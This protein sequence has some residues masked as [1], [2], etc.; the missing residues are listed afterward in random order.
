LFI[1]IFY[2]KDLFVGSQPDP[3]AMKGGILETAELEDFLMSSVIPDP[4]VNATELKQ[5]ISDELDRYFRMPSIQDSNIDVLMFWRQHEINFPLL[6]QLARDV[7]CIPA[8]SCSSERLF[9]ATGRI[10]TSAR[11][12]LSPE[13]TEDLVYIQKN[14]PKVEKSISKWKMSLTDF[15]TSS[16]TTQTTDSES[17]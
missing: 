16:T 17:E 15:K 1:N 13:R 3:R 9:S 5:P 12:N 7:L 2:F 14:F 10:V 4:N 6:A 11:C 8:T